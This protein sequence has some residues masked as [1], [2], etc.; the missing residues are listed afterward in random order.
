M[1]D[2]GEMAVIKKPLQK[3]PYEILHEKKETKFSVQNFKQ[4]KQIFLMQGNILNGGF[5]RYYRA[6]LLAALS[7]FG[8]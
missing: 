1:F 5:P 2:F 7:L 6:R 8:D 4:I 3:N